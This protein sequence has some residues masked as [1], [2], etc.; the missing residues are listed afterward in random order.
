MKKYLLFVVILCF[1]A[2]NQQL[3]C[4]KSNSNT[5]KQTSESES[6]KKFDQLARAYCEKQSLDT[7]KSYARIT[8]EKAEKAFGKDTNYC[9]T[10]TLLEEICFYKGEYK[11]SID[12]CQAEKKYRGH[13]QGEQHI[14]YAKIL[15]I[16]TMS[17][18]ATAN[19]TVAEQVILE[20][21][22]ILKKRSDTVNVEYANSLSHLAS[23]YQVLDKKAEAKALY[24]EVLNIRKTLLGTKHPDYADA[25]ISLGLLYGS[26]GKHEESEPLLLEASKIYKDFFGVKSRYYS[27]SLNNLGALYFNLGDYKKAELFLI[28]ALNIDKEMLGVD[29]S[30]YASSLNNI[31][32]LY[33]RM[34]NQTAAEPL[35]LEAVKLH[36][37]NLGEKHPSY[38]RALGNLAIFYYSMGNY[39]AAEPLFLEV[40]KCKKDYLGTKHSDYGFSLGNLASLY[41]T[42]GK[43][44]EAE[45]CFL[46]AMQIQKE[47]N[48]EKHPSYAN[49]ISNLSNLY[50]VMGNYDAAEILLTQALQIRKEV[51]GDKHPD[52][53][54]ALG[55]LAELYRVMLKFEASEKLSLEALEI[56]K[57][58][59]GEKHP[60]Y[61]NSLS[62]LATLYESMGNYK[63]AESLYTEAL[64]IK[65]ENQGIRHPNY[66]QTLSISAGL[67]YKMGAYT[68]AEQMYSEVLN[69]FKEIHGVKHQNYTKILNQQA[70][71]YTALKMYS[72]AE[73]L[74]LTCVKQIKEEVHRNFSFLSEKEKEL[75]FKTQATNFHSFYSFSLNRKIANPGITAEVYNTLITN[76][77]L[78]LKSSTAMRSSVLGSN[79]TLLIK[80]YNQ[81]T[82]LKKEISKL[83]STEISKRKKDPEVLE[84]EA[85][86]LE[87]ELVK[88]SSAFND[89]NKLQNLTWLDVQKSL[90]KGEASIEFVNFN[91]GKK[92][93][94][95][96]YCALLIT[97]QSKYPEM[98]RLFEEKDLIKVLG[99]KSETGDSY[100]TGI[101]G[102]RNNSNTQLY[103]LIWKPLERNLK[104]IKTIYYSPSGLLHKISFAALNKEKDIYLCDNYRL[105]L[106]GSTA[107]LLMPEKFEFTDRSVTGIFGDI[108]YDTPLTI[109]DTTALLSWPYLEG[110]KTESEK[111]VAILSSNNLNSTYQ[112]GKNA[113]EAEFKLKAQQSNVIH[114]ATHGFF[115]SDPDAYTYAEKQDTGKKETL[116]LRGG[117]RAIG[118]YNFLVNKNP[119][120]R[121]GLVF[122]GANEVWI[123]EENT[124]KEDG[125][126]TAQ[127]VATLDLRK[128]NL[129]VLSA[130]ETGLGDIKGT[131]GVYG[132]QRS[133]KMAGVKY[134]IMSLWQVPDSE[135]VEFMEKFYTKLVKL[136]DI[137]TS[138]YETRNEM[139]K[140]YDPF[141]WA[142]FVLLE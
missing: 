119:L 99:I 29:H 124:D 56:R 91:E 31:A 68:S 127:E 59:L 70:K 142:A 23:L 19:Y 87:K 55:N 3:Y 79:D 5:Q 67:Y 108:Q 57:V 63:K 69:I 44:N 47:T 138:F 6:F 60:D 135:T 116:S 16:M 100:I 137:K 103:D 15:N 75:Y 24:K 117:N 11:E 65:K 84:K 109:K 46:Q 76:K 2:D 80:Q 26:L 123:R 66:A 105:E 133:L 96:T 120:M 61:A 36:K 8:L 136:K 110:T 118:V 88:K 30:D 139:R 38:A 106:Q 45:L 25:L 17:Y 58:T 18:L 101:Y 77:G 86:K 64:K 74:F 126:L 43:N 78:L 53:A 1:F 35:M 81:W 129:V 39:A 49:A 13:F 72:T 41:Q 111:I 89:L 104:G 62:N 93:D 50:Y 32:Q 4:Q 92:N 21:I 52:Y 140:K 40:L 90:K 131:E 85:N 27:I 98:I 82:A 14:R 97:P 12:Y 95:V 33:V 73:P 125:V 22:G 37:K 132:L 20:A 48:G 141:Y 122:A 34:G 51:H 114:I 121:S 10:L 71:V 54:L 83:N 112:N 107:K 128:T 7:A 102:K 94:T 42:M 28:E 9:N 134:I 115:F 130:C 113:T